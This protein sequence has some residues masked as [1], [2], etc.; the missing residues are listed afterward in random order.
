MTQNS[1]LVLP[2]GLPA[3]FS[4]PDDGFVRLCEFLD[5]RNRSEQQGI[6]NAD[7]VKR[8]VRQL[9]SSVRGLQTAKRL[10]KLLTSF[11]G[12][13]S[14][15]RDLWRHTYE[16][17]QDTSQ[18]SH[19]PV[20]SL[21]YKAL[22]GYDSAFLEREV[23]E[24]H[25]R[26]VTSDFPEVIRSIDDIPEWQCHALA[27]WPDLRRDLIEWDSLSLE[28]RDAVALAVMA[29]ATILDDSRFLLWAASRA[30]VLAREFAFVR[31]PEAKMPETDAE[32][33]QAPYRG[34]A[35]TS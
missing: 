35:A 5:I 30:D 19:Y 8:A 27:I 29:V 28:R 25:L 17:V 22:M 3:R 15:R 10:Q 1:K 20:P 7:G 24:T 13:P 16:A 21:E 31:E 32:K 33:P 4:D 23:D 12:L 34:R 14:E 18:D 9:R 11:Y 2:E 6:V 26:E